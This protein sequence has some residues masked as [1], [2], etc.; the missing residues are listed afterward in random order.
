M[1]KNNTSTYEECIPHDMARKCNFCS[2]FDFR[3]MTNYIWISTSSSRILQ[4]QVIT[5]SHIG[6]MFMFLV[7]NVPLKLNNNLVLLDFWAVDYNQLNQLLCW[8]TIWNLLYVL[9]ICYTFE[10]KSMTFTSI[11]EIVKFVATKKRKNWNLHIVW[12]LPQNSTQAAVQFCSTLH[13]HLPQRPQSYVNI[14][15]KLN[16]CPPNP[17]IIILRGWKQPCPN[18]KQQCCRWALIISESMWPREEA[19][20]WWLS[21]SCHLLL[22]CI[23]CISPLETHISAAANRG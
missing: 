12:N 2:V 22:I 5:G 14:T 18:Q 7:G 10:G 1:K 16:D 19:P 11:F 8:K 15:W 17:S 3:I 21:V 13:R 4:F 9:V 6:A 20:A 23:L